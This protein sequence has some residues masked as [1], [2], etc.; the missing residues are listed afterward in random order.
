MGLAILLSAKSSCRLSWEQWSHPLHLLGPVL[1]GWW[2]LQ[3]T[4]LSS[5]IVLQ[6]P[7]L[8]QGWG[9]HPLYLSGDC[10]VLM[11]LHWPCSCTAQS[12]ILSIGS[13]CRSSVRHLPERSW[14]VVTSLCFTVVKS[15]T[16]WYALLLM[17]FLRF[18]SISLHWSPI[19][20]SLAFLMYL[21][22][23]LFTSLY[24]S[25]PSGSNLFFLSS[26]L[27]SHRSR[28]SAVIQGFLF[29]QCLPRISLAAS[30]TAVLKVVITESMSVSSLLMMVRGAN[31]PPIIAWKVSNTLGSSSFSRSNLSLVCFGLLI[32]FRRRWKVIIS[33]S[34]SL[35]CLLLENFMFWHCS[36]FIGSASSLECNQSGHGVVHLG[37]DRFI[38]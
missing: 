35:Q 10:S 14:T 3:L 23:L 28:I 15:F 21:L 22:M 18:S 8:C 9:G 36:L 6:P 1:L 33:K 4:S 32:L 20:F 7:L 2:Q 27:L 31:L 5:V 38:F 17:F 25:D 37:Y 24:F 34:W 30:V 13:V 11:D 19:Q 29:W 26:L 12:S 16:S